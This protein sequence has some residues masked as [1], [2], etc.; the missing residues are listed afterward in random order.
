MEASDV[1]FIQKG[2]PY[3]PKNCIQSK[4]NVVLT[5]KNGIKLKLHQY[6][7]SE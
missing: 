4:A 6:I 5:L 3:S 2:I 7:C 1:S